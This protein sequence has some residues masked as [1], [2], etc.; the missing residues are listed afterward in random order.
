LRGDPQL[1]RHPQK[2]RRVVEVSKGWERRVAVY[3]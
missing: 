3:I 2:L 1:R